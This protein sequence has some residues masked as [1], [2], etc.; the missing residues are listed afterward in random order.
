MVWHVCY[1][2]QHA[3]QQCSNHSRQHLS[4]INGWAGSC[5]FGISSHLLWFLLFMFRMSRLFCAWLCSINSHLEDFV[6]SSLVCVCHT[7]VNPWVQYLLSTALAALATNNPLHPSQ[8]HLFFCGNILNQNKHTN[9]TCKEGA[10]FF[11]A[12]MHLPGRLKGDWLSNLGCLTLAFIFQ[13]KT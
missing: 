13:F 11:F 9:P 1:T 7:T 3:A 10:C 12:P 8:I 4:M 5:L 6:G 2:W